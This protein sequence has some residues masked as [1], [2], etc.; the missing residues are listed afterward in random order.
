MIFHTVILA[1]ALAVKVTTVPVYEWKLAAPA[2]SG[3]FQPD[4]SSGKYPMAIVPVEGADGRLYLIGDRQIWSSGDGVRWTGPEKKTDWGPRY[5]NRIVHFKGKFW[6]LGGM[7]SWDDFKND[8]WSSADGKEW[9]RVD[10]TAAWRP[11]RGHAGLVFDERI[12]IFGGSLSSGRADKTPT[13]SLNDVWASRDGL[14]WTRVVEHAPWSP[15]EAHISFVFKG[16]MWTIGGKGMQEIWSSG[17]GR[18]WTL[19]TDSAEY[20]PRT[21]AGAAVMDGRIWIYGGLDKNDVWASSDGST[22]T[23]MFAETPWST[24]STTYSGVYK[25]RL[26]LFSGKNGRADTQTGEIWAMSRKK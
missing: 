9:I 5:G 19:Q 26:L 17:N 2:G 1:L 24:R 22:W 3:C 14:N 18:D 25:D 13:E 21:G 10:E 20:G 16:R 15:R 7:R 12:W 4:C 23:Q 6:M 11:R 8:V